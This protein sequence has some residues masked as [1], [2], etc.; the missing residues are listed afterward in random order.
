[1]K[2]IFLLSGEDL[3]MARDEVMALAGTE[4]HW[5]FDNVLVLDA[6]FRFDRLSLTRKVYQHLFECSYADL[7]RMMA[8]YDWKK[9]YRN[10][11]SLRIINL[12]P[13]KLPDKEALLA[14][15]IWNKVREPRVDLKHAKT[16]IEIIV[17]GEKIF[18]GLV[19]KDINNEFSKR[20]PNTRPG[21]H[22]TTISPKLAKA[23]I[24]LTGIPVGKVLVDPFCGTGG[25]MIEGGLMRFNTIGYDISEKMLKMC[26][27]NLDYFLIKRFRIEIQDAT[28]LRNLLDYVVTD[29][30]Y[31]KSSKITDKLELLYADFLKTL[32]NI[33]R[34]KAVIIFPNSIDYLALLNKTGFVVEKTYNVYVHK[35]LS[36]NIVLIS[37]PNKED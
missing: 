36:R 34:Y 6:D 9:V 32:E 24:N 16:K 25:I 23:C 35:S 15:H 30:P 28:T 8:E 27:R 37:K 21:R 20:R 13:V 31:G 11:F 1:M 33:L 22:P 19:K 14:K 12:G 4:D 29:L 26:H 7:D 10:H 2:C 5:M 18:V 3:D 17:T